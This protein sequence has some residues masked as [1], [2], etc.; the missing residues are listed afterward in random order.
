M[1][2][3]IFDQHERLI[4]KL[5]LGGVKIQDGDIIALRYAVLK[6]YKEGKCSRWHI[7]IENT[8]YKVEKILSRLTN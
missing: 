8:F 7:F 3:P 2:K 4:L 5:H 6:L 1:K